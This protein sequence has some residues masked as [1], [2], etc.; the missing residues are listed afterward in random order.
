METYIS[1]NAYA[2]DFKTINK[3]GW[4]CGYVHIPKDH[5]ILVQL[6]TDYGWGNYL[7]PKDCPEEITFS[8]WDKDNEYF[9][10]GF[11]TAHIHNN[12]SHD[13]AYVTSQ[14]NLIKEIVDTYTADYADNY[15][16]NAIDE[17][18]RKFNKYLL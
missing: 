6:V 1:T 16:R 7:S 5:P 9:I 13:E 2:K 10:I 18:K 4:G 14:A 8:S 17:V 3:T 12:D 15:A 11:D